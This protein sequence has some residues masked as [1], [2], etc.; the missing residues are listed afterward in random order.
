MHKDE[1]IPAVDNGTPLSEALVEI[2]QKGLGMTAVIDNSRRVIGVFTDGDLRRA[3]DKSID[4]HST[5]IDTVLTPH[6]KTIGAK[7]LAV[8]A[9]K[10]MEEKKINALPVVDEHGVLIGALNMHDLLRSG[11]V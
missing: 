6:C 4:I 5:S 2:T 7:Q 8:E 1:R 10:L 9:A 11:V 3:L